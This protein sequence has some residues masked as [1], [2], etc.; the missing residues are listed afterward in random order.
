MGSYKKNKGRGKSQNFVMLRYDI[1]DSVAWKALS[2]N[3]RCV[4]IEVMRR[5]KG[6]NNGDI[7]LSCREA[8]EFCNI[9]KDTAA[10]CFKELQDKGF[11]KIAM[12]A[13]FR[14]KQRYSTRWVITHE[15]LNDQPPTNEWRALGWVKKPNS[16]HVNDENDPIKI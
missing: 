16:A 12:I 5:Y 15:R 1:L 10:R 6:Y 4:W 3:A 13:G 7:P 11:I 9:G 8:A 14:N 2:P